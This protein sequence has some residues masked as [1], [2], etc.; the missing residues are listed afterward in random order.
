MAEGQK[1]QKEQKE[2][3]NQAV[4]S[5]FEEVETLMSEKRYDD[6]ILLLVKI[7]QDEP[8]QMERVQKK[9]LEIQVVKGR[10]NELFEQLNKAVAVV[11]G[12]KAAAIVSQIKENYPFLNRLDKNR[13]ILSLSIIEKAVDDRIRDEYFQK[14]QVFISEAKYPEAVG[15][16]REGY[17][18]EQ[19]FD[20]TTY[21][22]YVDFFAPNKAPIEK[23]AGDEER[24]AQI[25]EVY[26]SVAPEGDVVIE[27]LKPV[28]DDWEKIVG[29]VEALN[30]T[31]AA[32]LESGEPESW[33][34]GLNTAAGLLEELDNSRTLLDERGRELAGVWAR[35]YSGLQDTPEEF[36]YERIGEFL[37][38][39]NGRENTEGILFTQQEFRNKTYLSLVQ[40][41]GKRLENLI[42][43]GRASYLAGD[44]N[45]AAAYFGTARRAAEKLLGFEPAKGNA[46][47]IDDIWITYGRYALES[48][49]IREGLNT[50]GEGLPSLEFTELS[51]IDLAALDGIA[52]PI[53]K[54]VEKARELRQ[55][56][57]NAETGLAAL[58]ASESVPSQ[59]L[60]QNLREDLESAIKQFSGYRLSL[61][62]NAIAPFYRQLESLIQNTMSDSLTELK[63]YALEPPERHPSK[64]LE[65]RLPP[66]QARIR[67]NEEQL[68]R[69]LGV[70]EDM[71][72]RQ[73]P[74]SNPEEVQKYGT[75]AEKLGTFV[76]GYLSEVNGIEQAA[77]RYVNTARRA[78][79]RGNNALQKALSS[80]GEARQAVKKG[81]E[82]NN[83]NYFYQAVDAYNAAS[84]SLDRVEVAYGEIVSSDVDI[85]ENSGLLEELTRLRNET[86]S[87]QASVAVSV[88]DNAI[89]EGRRAYEEQSYLEGVTV[90]N[91]AQSFWERTY[92]EPDAELTAWTIRLKNAWQA[93]Q[94]TAIEP[95]DPLFSEMNQYLNLAN[96]Y[97]TE[98]LRLAEKGN[99]SDSLRSFRSA[100][101]LLEQVLVPFPGNESALLLKQKI[102]RETDYDAWAAS[103]RELIR[104]VLIALNQNNRDA[105]IGRS[106]RKGLYSD[107][108]VLRKID[109]NFAGLNQSVYYNRGLIYDVEVLIG[110]IQPPPDPQA[111][112]RSR[113]LT[114]KARKIW[115]AVGTD[116]A[117]QALA[118]LNKALE[119]WLENTEASSLRNE[120][121]VQK[122]PAPIPAELQGRLVY[123]D[124]FFAEE[125]FSTAK[126]IIEQI[127]EQFP[128]FADDPRILQRLKQVEAR[129]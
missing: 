58:P 72:Q 59:T 53:E 98:G 13:L 39:R 41:M 116:G 108:L 21:R 48:L 49:T 122:A 77:R 86:N 12:D 115:E 74:I 66:L 55:L 91:Q 31:M 18:S 46:A 127:R 19:Y 103:A 43:S 38:G 30:I 80:L 117:S 84:D 51:A 73:P 113:R 15:V 24:Q 83:I 128:A 82:T 67:S 20:L 63:Q 119:E 54:S 88:K 22:D 101:E 106:D 125:D 75:K 71:L 29:R 47:G 87:E 16:Y 33:D 99:A 110:R 25:W 23:H 92:G 61:Y 8:E 35:L 79:T 56:W 111:I 34:A 129:Q 78:L 40:L 9:I 100:E 95:N 5:R 14:A 89:V 112:A 50:L 124:K 70:V 17:T 69:F 107:L 3:I 96:R 97:F 94:Q 65:E 123:F 76:S 27:T 81:Q 118:L 105:F 52:Q 36:Y 28:L 37:Y 62:L 104:S 44:W 45:S 90:L 93:L 11:D 4:A 7:G 1:E 102:L 121:A 120:I 126:L 26:S 2:Q 6:A 32:L 10:L 64:T 42:Q 114:E 109:P 85:A 68:N 57:Q 60:D